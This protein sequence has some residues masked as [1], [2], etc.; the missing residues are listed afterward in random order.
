MN[1]KIT[2]RFLASLFAR[3]CNTHTLASL[4]FSCPVQSVIVLLSSYPRCR[5]SRAHEP[6]VGTKMS[7]PCHIPTQKK[8]EKDWIYAWKYISFSIQ[9]KSSYLKYVKSKLI[10]KLVTSN[11]QQGNCR[12]Q[13]EDPLWWTV[14]SLILDSER[15]NDMEIH[16][17][18]LVF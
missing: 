7:I 6:N 18:G 13:R 2:V 17:N 12:L 4:S 11:T 1:L 3:L 9:L 8:K 10:W 16:L 14:D 5:L 15:D